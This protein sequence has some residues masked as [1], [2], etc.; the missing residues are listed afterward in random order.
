[1][2]TQNKKALLLE[3]AHGDPLSNVTTLTVPIFLLALYES[4]S[5]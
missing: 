2:E 1:M 5:C 3:W 4:W